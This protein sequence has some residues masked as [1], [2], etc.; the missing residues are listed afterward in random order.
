MLNNFFSSYLY[1]FE[2]LIKV[3]EYKIK[4]TLAEEYR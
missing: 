3:T 4:T 1:L 2:F